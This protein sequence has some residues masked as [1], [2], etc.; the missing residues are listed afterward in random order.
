MKL[1][2]ISAELLLA[3]ASLI[4]AGGSLVRW[5]SLLELVVLGFLGLAGSAT[6]NSYLDR[7]VDAIMSRTLDRPIPSGRIKASL[8]LSIGIGML[9]VS[10]VFTVLLLN[11]ITA[12]IIG[13]GSA[14]YIL[15]YTMYLKR[16]TPNAVLW[17]GISGAI[18]ALGGWSV[19]NQSDWL[20][21][22]LI[23]LVVFLWQPSHFWSLSIYY[24]EDFKSAKIPVLPTLKD[25]SEIAR[26]AMVFNCLVILAVYLLY[27]AGHLSIIFLVV[28]TVMNIV[29]VLA[30]FAAIQ[31]RP[32]EFYWRNFRLSLAYMLVFLF[33]LIVSGM[34][35]PALRPV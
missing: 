34:L 30:S 20:I 33:S 13:V 35:S 12:L 10:V 6:V 27:M 7:D 24:R 4:V 3:V 9:I 15:F 17:G 28:M 21:P 2:L 25:N 8:A 11:V 5:S 29:L 22:I 1:K 18:P 14:L 16:R 31:K 19:Y 32:K 26:R 23:F